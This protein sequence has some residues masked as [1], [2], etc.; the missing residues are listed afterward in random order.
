VPPASNSGDEMWAL[1]KTWTNPPRFI[2]SG[3]DVSGPKYWN[4]LETTPD[5]D[6][7]GA[8]GKK[9]QHVFTNLQDA[10]RDTNCGV[11]P[12]TWSSNASHLFFFKVRP[13]AGVVE[14]YGKSTNTNGGQWLINTTG[15]AVYGASP[16]LLFSA[17]LP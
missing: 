17:P 16:T 3:H 8:T 5:I 4:R 9:T 14:L 1:F 7:A 12:S 15:T 6:V 11:T 2:F 10:D 13:E